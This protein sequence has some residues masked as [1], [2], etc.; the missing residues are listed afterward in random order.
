MKYYIDLTLIPDSEANLGFLWH[1]V[2]QQLH[3]AL[4]ENKNSD[5]GSAV[6][7]SFPNYGDNKFPLGNKLRLLANSKEKLTT[8]DV[9]KWLSRLTDYTHCTSIKDVPKS[10][11]EY[12]CFK[13]KQFMTNIS[14]QARRRVKR[15]GGTL[16]KALHYYA[17]LEDEK[18]NL[19]FIN[20]KSLSHDQQFRL[21][22]EC[23]KFNQPISGQFNCYGLSKTNATVPWF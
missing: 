18:T 12:A 14:R 4:V 1:K 22:I 11:S 19:A 16:E 15:H 3:I 20:I 23:E 6:A 5:N 8:L 10:V 17:G 13:R 2:Y 21:F 7:L 9:N